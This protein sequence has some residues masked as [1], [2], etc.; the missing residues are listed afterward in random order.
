[1]QVESTPE[2]RRRAEERMAHLDSMAE[3]QI[4]LDVLA[5]AMW[6]RVGDEAATSLLAALRLNERLEK[7]DLR[8][9]HISKDHP[10][11]LDERVIGD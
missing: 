7:V 5:R 8:G 1:M 9:N 3:S 10:I 4:V 2:E 6:G 11:W